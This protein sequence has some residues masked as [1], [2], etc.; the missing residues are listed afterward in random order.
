MEQPGN[1]SGR[2]VIIPPGAG[3]RAAVTEEINGHVVTSRFP[4]IY[5]D[6]GHPALCRLRERERLDEVVAGAETD[7]DRALRLKRWV[8]GQWEFGSPQPYPPWNA[9]EILDWIR[10]GKTG[11][12]CG[13]YAM[14]FLQSWLSL[15]G[16]GRYVEL[17][18]RDNPYCHFTT[19]LWLADL[20]K[21]AILDATSSDTLRCHYVR[22]GVPLSALEIHRAHLS[23]QEAGVGFVVEG[24][25]Q[26]GSERPATPKDLE[27]YYRF[28]VVFRNNQ[29]S[30]PPPYTDINNTF[31]RYADC[32][33]WEDEWTVPWPEF[34]G[35][36]RFPVQ[37]M[38]ARST[39]DEADLYYTL[40]R[41]TRI[42]VGWFHDDLFV[43][44][45]TANLADRGGY[46]VRLDGGG[47]QA[48]EGH[49][50]WTAGPGHHAVEA[51][52]L[53]SR[54]ER[55]PVSRIGFELARGA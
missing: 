53:T 9:L 23:G 22:E 46:E 49:L 17:S 3:L 10:S 38:S 16:Q 6:P 24:E 28:R 33:E 25:S 12:F 11:G 43:V 32:V 35:E 45:L 37:R 26:G 20:G 27:I 34:P 29:L 15:G 41:E 5:Q 7:L 42:E 39:R 54:G 36:A 47:W 50:G 48:C 21:W 14:V 13:Q 44:R 55:G 52:A 2:P 19:E 4:F 40:N 31:D 8:Q 30:D 1:G 18:T 51:R